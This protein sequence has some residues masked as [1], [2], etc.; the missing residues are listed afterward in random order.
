MIRTII[1]EELDIK[2]IKFHKNQYGKP[3]L[4]EHPKFNFNISHSGNFVACVVD[5]KPV[6]IDIE[7]V[8]YIEY[9]EIAKN[10][11]TVSE[12]CYIIKQNLN[13]QLSKFYEIWILKESYIKC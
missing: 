1:V 4:K 2:N 13:D 6:G 8:R 11:F 9:E 10:F 5:D 12:F 7:E 3:Y